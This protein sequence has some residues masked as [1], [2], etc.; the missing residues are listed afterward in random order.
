M[1]SR[2]YIALFA[3]CSLVSVDL[4]AGEHRIRYLPK[5]YSKTADAVWA[6]FLE[7]FGGLPLQWTATV[8]HEILRYFFMTPWGKKAFAL[9]ESMW[10]FHRARHPT[11]LAA[12]R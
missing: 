9:R 4:V 7:D 10:I 1:Q 5:E 2:V 8:D 12:G 6:S 3:L 11:R